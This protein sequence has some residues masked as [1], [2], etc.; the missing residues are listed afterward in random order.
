MRN[1]LAS[2]KQFCVSLSAEELKAIYEVVK[3]EYL[4]RDSR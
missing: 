4:G 3:N 2:V 1:V